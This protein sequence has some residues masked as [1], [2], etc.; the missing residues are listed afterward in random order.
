[1]HGDAQ[2][3]CAAAPC[4][5]AGPGL[6]SH[7]GIVIACDVAARAAVQKGLP[8]PAKSTAST[9]SKSIDNRRRLFAMSA[10]S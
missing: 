2:S 7:P 1:M 8:G 9:A 5:C 4:F 10:P 6:L 3:G